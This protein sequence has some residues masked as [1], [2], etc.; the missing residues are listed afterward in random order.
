MGAVDLAEY[1]LQDDREQSL[2]GSILLDESVISGLPPVQPSDFS[3]PAHRLIFQVIQERASQGLPIDPL[4]VAG[5]LAASGFNDVGVDVAYLHSLAMSVVSSRNAVAYANLVLDGAKERRNVE[6]R[7]RVQRIVN[8]GGDDWAEKLQEY[9]SVE[10]ARNDSSDWQAALRQWKPRSDLASFSPKVEFAVHGLIQCG[11]VG[12]LVAAGGTGKTTLLLTLG[13]CIALG[14]PFFGCQVKQGSFV[15]L[16]N[17]DSQE[18]LDAAL[19]RVGRAVGLSVD[20]WDIVAQKFRV[21]SLH[22]RGGLKTFTEMSGGATV[23]T[24]LELDILKAVGKIPDLVGIALD[25]L[26]QFSGG[27]S[28]DEQVIKLTIAGATEIAHKTGA[29]VVFPHHT[30]KQNYRD[31]VVDMYCGSGSAAIADNCRFVLLL[32]TATWSDIEMK[33]RRTG[34]EQGSPLVLTSTRGSLLVPAPEPIYLHR[35][36]FLIERIEG[37]VMSGA[38]IADERDRAILDAVRRG[39]QTKNAIAAAVRGKRS[40]V[41]GQVDQLESRGYLTRGSQ[42]GSQKLMVSAL[43]ARLLDEWRNPA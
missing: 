24:G 42:D 1:G 40:A 28:N 12:A 21:M 31:A 7:E 39:A 22:G 33:V 4:A 15:L 2:L 23:A 37:D 14:I 41:L 30:G 25:T 5:D 8:D 27:N 36:G 26:R 34:C 13:I 35:N 16:S 10:R 38:Q 9:L 11:K 17:D 18:D 43:G 32:Q 29:F 6:M 19:A 3:H 20:E